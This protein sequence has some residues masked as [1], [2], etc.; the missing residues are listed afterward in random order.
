MPQTTNKIFELAIDFTVTKIGTAG[1]AE[2]FSNGLFTYNKDASN[3]IE[4]VNIGTINNTTFNTTIANTLS[5][6]AEWLTSNVLNTI[7]S[8]NFTLTKTY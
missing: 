1:V 8:Q 2:I 6:T 4:G 3:A 7:R 5:I